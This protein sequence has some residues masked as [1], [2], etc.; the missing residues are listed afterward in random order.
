[1]PIRLRLALLF[2]AG[3]AALIAA[4]GW[5][6]T[7]ELSSGLRGSAATTLRARVAVI[8]QDLPDIIEDDTAKSGERSSSELLNRVGPGSIAQ[9]FGPTGHLLDSTGVP[10]H[11]VLLRTSQV[12]GALKHSLL[13]ESHI[14][15][16]AVPILI[17]AER[18]RIG[19]FVV[20]AGTPLAAMDAAVTRVKDDLVAGGSLTVVLSGLAAWLLGGAALAPVA[21]LRRQAAEISADDADATLVVPKSRDEIADLATTLN[22]MLSRLSGAL[23]RQRGFVAVAGHELRTPLSVLRGELELAARPGR[24]KAELVA[25]VR[26]AEAEADR[27]ICLAEDLL[28]L[29]RVDAVGSSVPPT[30]HDVVIVATDSVV[31]FSEHARR[32]QV[33]LELKAPSVL[34]ALVDPTRLR[35]VFD[36]LL[37][38][39]LRYSPPGS[40]VTVTLGHNAKEVTADVVDQG[41]G[42]P[43]EFLPRALERFSRADEN[44]DR[45]YGGSGLGLA[46]VKALVEAHHGSVQ[47]SNHPSG[48]AWVRVVIPTDVFSN[49]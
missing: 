49:T 36:N 24:S 2:A 43:P 19:K 9:V 11:I 45:S 16:A 20:L 41:P 38:N 27:I 17:L 39:A 6:F 34:M 12:V 3:T 30:L 23:S 4:G 1:M 22:A 10:F 7:T 44:R 14:T 31:A 48:G 13:V 21:R 29:A 33:S 8:N 47:V 35:Q 46:V 25:A 32:G 40:A 18:A 5:F 42:F 28:L 26:V 37:D 15:G